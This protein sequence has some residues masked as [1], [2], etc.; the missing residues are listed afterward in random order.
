MFVHVCSQ[1]L[2]FCL[3]LFF[4]T[5]FRKVFH[6]HKT[7]LWTLLWEPSGKYFKLMKTAVSFKPEHDLLCQRSQAVVLTWLSGGFL[8]LLCFLFEWICLCMTN[9][10]SAPV[11]TSSV[12][13]GLNRA[14]VCWHLVFSHSLIWK[15]LRSL[16]CRDVFFWLKWCLLIAHHSRWI[17]SERASG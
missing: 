7:K 9:R 17:G 12:D 15:Q 4:Y 16:L 1:H 6:Y 14:I 8:I 13:W 3:V 10:Q 11:L 5:A 2:S